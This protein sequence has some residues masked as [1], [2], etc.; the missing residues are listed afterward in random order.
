MVVAQIACA[1][2]TISY[3]LAANDG[4]NLRLLVGY[5]MMKNQPKLTWMIL[6]Q[7]F[8]SGLFR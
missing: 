3:K 6:F 7:A 5:R 4:M 1:V 2:M 8:L